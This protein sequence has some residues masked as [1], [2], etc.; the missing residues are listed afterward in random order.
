MLID[1]RFLQIL[2]NMN[3]FTWKEEIKKKLKLL[4]DH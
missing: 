3:I 2:V 4:N 1:K